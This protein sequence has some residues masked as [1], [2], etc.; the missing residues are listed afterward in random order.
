MSITIWW[1]F[2]RQQIHT[3]TPVTDPSSVKDLLPTLYTYQKGCQTPPN[4]WQGWIKQLKLVYVISISNV[5]RY[6]GETGSW[7]R[8]LLI[9]YFHQR[10]RSF[11]H[12]QLC[13]R[14]YWCSNVGQTQGA[15]YR[16]LCP[17]QYEMQGLMDDQRWWYACAWTSHDGAL[18]ALFSPSALMYTSLV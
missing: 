8:L 13:W 4:W 10:L 16:W 1:G 11:I 3:S 18:C 6:R 15:R 5:I 14:F 12:N 17:Q 2:A 9:Q 7:L